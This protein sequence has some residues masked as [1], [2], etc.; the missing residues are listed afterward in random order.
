MT[1]LG[2]TQDCKRE[3]VVLLNFSK[4]HPNFRKIK[5]LSETINNEKPH[6]PSP[7]DS[8]LSL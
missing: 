7:E 2:L 8:P 6:E 4:N 1:D 5:F 3:R